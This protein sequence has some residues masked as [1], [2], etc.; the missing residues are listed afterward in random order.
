MCVLTALQ[1]SEGSLFLIISAGISDNQVRD[2]TEIID[3]SPTKKAKFEFVVKTGKISKD[4]GKRFIVS[5]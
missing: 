4:V 3:R 2:I 5:T 1:R